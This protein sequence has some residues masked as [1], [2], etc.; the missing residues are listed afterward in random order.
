MQVT[1]NIAKL[2]T[3]FCQQKVAFGGTWD[4]TI[5]LDETLC[6]EISFWQ[7]NIKRLNNWFCKGANK[8]SVITIISSDASNSGCGAICSDS[9]SISARLFSQEEKL[10]HS[11]KRE[12]LGGLHALQSLITTIKNSFVKL[13]LDNQ[14]SARIIE[15]GSMKEDLHQ[16]AI[17][18][19][20][21][22]FKEGIELQVEWIPREANEAADLASRTAN[23]IDVDDWQLTPVFFAILDRM[24]GPMSI[25]AFANSYNKKINR[26][27][28][29]FHSPGCEGINAF[30]Y[31]WSQEFCLL[32]PPVSVIGKTLNHL[33]LCK[34][35]A[36]LVVPEWH[37][38]YFWPILTY[39]FSHF[40]RHKLTAR[41]NI[42]LSHGLNTNSILGSENLKCNVTA[43]LID[44]S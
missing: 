11:T 33:L 29:L 10:F 39:N 22:C 4:D 3:R 2:M 1:G 37:S 13:Q 42:V 7:S 6:K 38:S 8:P 9:V 36:V 28:S 31:D 15:C 14:S 25:D 26:F 35:K 27:F 34:A 44:C 16:I 24:W 17:S 40:I 20:E 41:G 12:L 5:S 30:A 32:V 19:F 21:L 18:I 23:I 43:F